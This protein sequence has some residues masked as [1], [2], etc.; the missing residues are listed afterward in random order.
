MS[1]SIRKTNPSRKKIEIL[2]TAI[3]I[4]PPASFT[5]AMTADPRKDAP[6]AKIS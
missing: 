4:V 5:A 6:L 3:L 1:A 2:A